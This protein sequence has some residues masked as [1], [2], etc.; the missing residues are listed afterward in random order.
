MSDGEQE[1]NNHKREHAKNR[2]NRSGFI[3]LN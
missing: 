3:K 1:M 2:N